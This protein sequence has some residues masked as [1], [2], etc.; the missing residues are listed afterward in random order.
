MHTRITAQWTGWAGGPGYTRLRWS[1]ALD[2]AAATDAAAEMRN[3]FSAIALYLP[4]A[5]RITWSGQADIYNDQGQLQAPVQYTP[6]AF[7]AGTDSSTAWSAASGACVQWLTDA[8]TNNRRIRGRTFL[9]P[10]A[11]SAYQTD[12]TLGSPFLSAVQDA[13]DA[14]FASTP[15]NVVVSN[16][17]RPSQQEHDVTGGICNDRAAVLR[18]RRS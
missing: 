8:F 7:V 9:V 16:E 17:G 2:G 12:G 15:N 14:L 10:L 3:F 11:G 4:S 5:I 1:G 6:P 13:V 18:S